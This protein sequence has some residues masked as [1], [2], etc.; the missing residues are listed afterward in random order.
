MTDPP[1]LLGTGEAADRLHVSKSTVLR[2]GQA[3]L[4]DARRI[5]PKLWRYTEQSVDALIRAG[6]D[7]AA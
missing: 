2:Y 4:L 3:G 6:K 7:T 1:R 5:G